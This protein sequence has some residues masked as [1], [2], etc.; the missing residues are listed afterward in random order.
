MA[1]EMKLNAVDH[2]YKAI[3]DPEKG[4]PKT[5]SHRIRRM[6]FQ[7]QEQDYIQDPFAS[8]AFCWVTEWGKWE[9]VDGQLQKQEEERKETMDNDYIGSPRKVELAETIG[10]AMMDSEKPME[11]QPVSL[12]WKDGM[13]Q[14]G[15]RLRKRRDCSPMRVFVGVNVCWSCGNYGHYRGDLRCPKHPQGNRTSEWPIYRKPRSHRQKGV[16]R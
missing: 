5:T 2:W 6:I 10:E 15:G 9:Q 14:M 11:K 12:R 3:A 16:H 4:T 1:G 13:L 8:A 7:L